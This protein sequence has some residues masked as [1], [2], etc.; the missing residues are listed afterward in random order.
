MLGLLDPISVHCRVH[1][2][3]HTG[4]CYLLGDKFFTV[5]PGYFF[6]NKFRKNSRCF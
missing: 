2:I 6:K 1:D 3:V 4:L 5:S